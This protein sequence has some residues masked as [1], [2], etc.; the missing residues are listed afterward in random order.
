MTY[1]DN[2]KY[3]TDTTKGNDLINACKGREIWKRMNVDTLGHDT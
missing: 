1:L 3:W 2:V